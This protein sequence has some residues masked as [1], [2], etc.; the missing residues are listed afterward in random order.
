MSKNYPL[1]NT[2]I[3][4]ALVNWLGDKKLVRWLQDKWQQDDLESEQKIEDALTLLQSR[5]SSN[6]SQSQ[7]ILVPIHQSTFLI[8]FDSQNL[9]L[10]TQ[11]T[12]KVGSAVLHT[13]SY[14]N[15]S[16][17]HYLGDE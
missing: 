17:F 2:S 8:G 13:I 5:L 14:W 6:L 7:I 9:L 15:K 4:L 1:S 10:W 12:E 3:N 16:V 11:Q